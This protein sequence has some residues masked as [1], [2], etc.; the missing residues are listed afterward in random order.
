MTHLL[1]TITSVARYSKPHQN[2]KIRIFM[3]CWMFCFISGVR[4]VAVAD[5]SLRQSP[6]RVLTHTLL[7][8]F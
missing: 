2:Q 6:I 4:R 5:R 7:L 1:A 3:F 8:Y